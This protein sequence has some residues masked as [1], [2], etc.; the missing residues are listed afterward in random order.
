MMADHDSPSVPSQSLAARCADVAVAAVCIQQF[1]HVFRIYSLFQSQV[2]HPLFY[3]LSALL[4]YGLSGVF[5]FLGVDEV[6][7][8]RLSAFFFHSVWLL[9]L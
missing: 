5:G 6:P 3:W 2:L 1:L 8:F 7:V 9:S 4:L